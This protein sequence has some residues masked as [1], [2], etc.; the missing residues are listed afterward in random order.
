MDEAIREFQKAVELSPRYAQAY[1]NL[2]EAYGR[3]EMYEEGLA[4]YRK[5]MA[6]DPV[7]REEL[8]RKIPAL[9]ELR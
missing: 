9:R 7:F 8:L 5:A 3:K 6:I 1:V 4:A 2:A